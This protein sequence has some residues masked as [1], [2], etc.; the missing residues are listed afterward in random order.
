MIQTT[1]NIGEKGELLAT[2]WLTEKGF[3]IVRQNLKIGRSEIDIVALKN[4]EI[5]FIAIKTHNGNGPGFPAE[6]F[7]K[8]KLEN[9][10][11]AACIYL[12][13]HPEMKEIVFDI[14]SIVLNEGKPDE[15][16]LLEDLSS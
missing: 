15:Y 7:G 2:K 11:S 5:H 3:F 13:D 14:L 12:M 4:G 1:G 8:K 9:L 10:R 16:V 6:N